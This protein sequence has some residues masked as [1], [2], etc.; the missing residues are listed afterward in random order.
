M[1]IIGSLLVLGNLLLYRQFVCL[2]SLLCCLTSIIGYPVAYVLPSLTGLLYY[3]TYCMILCSLETAASLKLQKLHSSTRFGADHTC[4]H[5]VWDPVDVVRET[6]VSS[7]ILVYTSDRRSLDLASKAR[8]A[9]PFREQL[10]YNKQSQFSHWHRVTSVLIKA[11]AFTMEISFYFFLAPCG[12]GLLAVES[13]SRTLVYHFL[14]ISSGSLPCS[15]TSRKPLLCTS[16][17]F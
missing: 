15:P 13:W 12:T 9:C 11:P 8:Q 7:C 6:I 10:T 4:E 5:Q 1:V 17:P 2:G 16:H 3:L 14:R